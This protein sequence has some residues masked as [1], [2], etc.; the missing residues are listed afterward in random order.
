MTESR[1]RRIVRRAVIAVAV[2]VLLP[3]GYVGSVATICILANA[4]ALPT[5]VHNSPLAHAYVAPVEWYMESDWP[6]ANACNTLIDWSIT[7]G[8]R[9]AGR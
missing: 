3:V 7:V 2:V 6:G 5:V 1:R 8:N 9:L 4:D